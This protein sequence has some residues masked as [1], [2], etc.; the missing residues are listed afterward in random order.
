MSTE[1]VAI[2]VPM[3]S[4]TRYFS[5]RCAAFI[6][7][8][9]GIVAAGLS[10]SA[11][12]TASV[13]VSTTLPAQGGFLTVPLYIAGESD[14]HL[15]C[16]YAGV[17]IEQVTADGI[18]VKR[19]SSV[20]EET[21]DD[22]AARSGS[23]LYQAVAPQMYFGPAAE[24]GWVLNNLSEN[25][26]DEVS[27]L[28]PCTAKTIEVFYRERWRNSIAGKLEVGTQ[29]YRLTCELEARTP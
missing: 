21:C 28:V 26:D 24:C 25:G 2:A 13:L 4:R 29:H 19:L 10:V 20:L 1:E 8:L 22:L 5:D 12:C 17:L 6:G 27:F 16:Y 15:T 7:M 14:V 23:Y 9:A 3:R 18:P 11:G